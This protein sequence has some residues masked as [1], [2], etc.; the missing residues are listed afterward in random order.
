MNINKDLHNNI[1]VVHAISPQAV[2]TTGIANGRL[3]GAI[4]RKGYSG[5]EFV[6]SAGASTSSADTVNP[7]VYEAEATNAAFTSVAD[8]D[9]LGT[10]AAI[11]AG[12]GAA[13]TK[14]IGYRGDKRYLKLRLYGLG[15]A[16]AAVAGAAILFNPQIA[17]VSD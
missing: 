15:T 12:P 8:A 9:L 4:D 6:Y 10:E 5:V 13:A 11:T 7:V 2:G 1:K 17:P 3:S 14:K 16:T